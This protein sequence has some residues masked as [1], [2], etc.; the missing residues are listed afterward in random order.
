MDQA[1]RKKWETL[2]EE[3]KIVFR[4]FIKLSFRAR[5]LRERPL[6]SRLPQLGF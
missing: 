3:K 6:K 4:S 5:P 1:E 2:G